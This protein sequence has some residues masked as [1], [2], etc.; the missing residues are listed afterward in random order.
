MNEKR[1]YIRVK[2]KPEEPV[3]IQLV[4]SNFIDILN[5]KDISEGGV[6]IIVDHDFEG[7]DIG[8]LIDIIITLPKKK[9]FKVKGR[10]IHKHITD[11]HFFGVEFIN[12]SEEARSMIKEYVQKRLEEAKEI[13]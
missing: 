1:R 11:S 6:G 2:P 5:A 7:C 9:T 13:K 12:I 8:G 3:E 10:I 4:G